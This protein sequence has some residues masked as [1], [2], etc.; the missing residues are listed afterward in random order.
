MNLIRKP[1]FKWSSYLY[2]NISAKITPITLSRT[3]TLMGLTTY[4]FD[5]LQRNH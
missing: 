4:Q 3:P 1:L 5:A 2:G